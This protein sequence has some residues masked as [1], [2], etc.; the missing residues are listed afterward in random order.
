VKF[1]ETESC[2]SLPPPKLSVHDMK[3]LGAAGTG[4]TSSTPPNR[5]QWFCAS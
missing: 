1:L 5:F 4:K 2:P 3:P